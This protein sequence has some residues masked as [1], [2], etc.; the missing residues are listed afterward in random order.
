ML[1]KK[2]GL[3]NYICSWIP[4]IFKNTHAQTHTH[5]KD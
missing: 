4:V 5:K 2:A 1:S 3:Q